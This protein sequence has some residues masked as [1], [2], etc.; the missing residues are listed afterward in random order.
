M[1]SSELAYATQHLG[2]HTNSYWGFRIGYAY[3]G[4]LGVD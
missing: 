1:R 2:Y 4:W 3:P